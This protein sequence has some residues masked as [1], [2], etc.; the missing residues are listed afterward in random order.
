ML[1][2]LGASKEDSWLVRWSSTCP[3]SHFLPPQACHLG[4]AV[5]R[6][7]GDAATTCCL[8]G[9]QFEDHKTLEGIQGLD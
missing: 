8:G 4:I 1:S 2:H 7:P 9:G 6:G 3:K 5:E